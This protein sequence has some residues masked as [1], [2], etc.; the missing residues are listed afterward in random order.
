[1]SGF[2]EIPKSEPKK[3]EGKEP[4]ELKIGQEVYIKR[5]TKSGGEIE[6][7]WKVNDFGQGIIEVIKIDPNDKHKIR[8]FVTP[9]ELKDWNNPNKI[10]P[11]HR[12]W[13]KDQET[14][15]PQPGWVVKEV[16]E[17]T[18]EYNI[19]NK[20]MKKELVVKANEIYRDLSSPKPRYSKKERIG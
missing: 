6:P 14:G 2:S 9:E 4:I 18:G 3:E 19:Y 5:S 11:G 10:V 20:T 8:K 7:G 17:E 15:L 1:M 16:N 12:I 13:Y